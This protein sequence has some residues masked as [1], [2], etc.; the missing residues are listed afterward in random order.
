MTL[1]NVLPALPL[2]N[3]LFRVVK[4]ARGPRANQAMP[5]LFVYVRGGGKAQGDRVVVLPVPRHHH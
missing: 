2:T 4:R 3:P 5:R 1:E